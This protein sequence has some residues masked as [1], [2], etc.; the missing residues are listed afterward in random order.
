MDIKNYDLM[1]WIKN[2][3]EI[4]PRSLS[5]RLK[6]LVELE[7]INK[8][9]FNEIPPRVEYSLTESGRDL[10]GFFK[11][12][13]EWGERWG[14]KTFLKANVPWFIKKSQF[15]I[16]EKNIHKISGFRFYRICSLYFYP[17]DFSK[18]EAKL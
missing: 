12:L 8:K 14:K 9:Q 11:G 13:E 4:T 5:Q 7:I 6:E 18:I 3:G 16:Y 17:L 15:I 10:T 1:N 2:I